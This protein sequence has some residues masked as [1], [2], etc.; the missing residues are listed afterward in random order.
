MGRRLVKLISE[1]HHTG[2]DMPLVDKNATMKEMI[3]IMTSKRLGCVVIKDDKDK[4]AGIFTDGDLRRLAEE[5][6]ELFSYIAADVMIKNPK[7]IAQ[8]AVLDAALAIMEK[9]SI[10]QLTRI[11]ENQKQGNKDVRCIQ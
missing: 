7:S 11:D 3:L 8:S 10:S 5:K 4:I 9:H 2:D 6:Q 1:L